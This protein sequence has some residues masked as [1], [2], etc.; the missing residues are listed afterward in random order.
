MYLACPP[1][2]EEHRHLGHLHHLLQ[3]EGSLADEAP[4]DGAIPGPRLEGR[5]GLARGHL[6]PP[7]RH[8]F[9]LGAGFGQQ[10]LFQKKVKVLPLFSVP[11]ST[12]GTPF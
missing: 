10:K 2:R 12:F 7:R 8:G 1:C 11:Y 3:E 6:P 4:K 5:Q 9:V